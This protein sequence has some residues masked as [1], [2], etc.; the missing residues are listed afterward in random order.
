VLQSFLGNPHIIYIISEVSLHKQS[1]HQIIFPCQWLLHSVEVQF[2][3][4]VTLYHWL[5]SSWHFEG[6]YKCW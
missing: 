4:D 5:Y 1:L 2:F 6:P 3:R